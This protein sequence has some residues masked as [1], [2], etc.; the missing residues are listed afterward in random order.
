MQNGEWY[1]NNAC[2]ENCTCMGNQLSCNSDYECS[3][4]ATC[5]EKTTVRKGY[6]NEG[7]GGDGE[8]CTALF[9]DCYDAY[10]AGNTTDGVYTILPT[11]W[12]GL[13]FNVSCD[14]TTDGG[15]WTVS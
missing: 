11:G 4:D 12:P 7:Y 15:G 6:C 14:M 1:V 9:T 8:I 3:H 5:T 13:P 10:L 2:S